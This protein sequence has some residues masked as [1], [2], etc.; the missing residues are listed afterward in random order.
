LK[1]ELKV[2]PGSSRDAVAGWLG[3]ALKIRVKAPPEHGRANAAVIALLADTL[4][5]TADRIAI[6]RGQSS[7]RKL[8]EIQGLT[9]RQV[10][11]RLDRG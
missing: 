7:P 2:V 6:S 1:L 8:V 11:D 4:G 3:D 10:R 5:I 9:E